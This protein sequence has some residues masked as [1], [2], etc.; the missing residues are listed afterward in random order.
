MRGEY[1]LFLSLRG[2]ENRQ[3]SRP[4]DWTG[5]L[6]R[7]R[8]YPAHTGTDWARRLFV[9]AQTV[10]RICER[11]GTWHIRVV[12]TTAVRHEAVA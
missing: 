5:P 11:P 7:L 2:R 10:A 9:L 3:P 6:K 8:F 1:A 4:A 12:R